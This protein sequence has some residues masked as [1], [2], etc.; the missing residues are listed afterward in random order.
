MGVAAEDAAPVIRELLT[1]GHSANLNDRI[2]EV[3]RDS[4]PRS[5]SDSTGIGKVS[6][7]QFEPKDRRRVQ[8]SP[9][10]KLKRNV[11]NVKSIRRVVKAS[12]RQVAEGNFLISENNFYVTKFV[13]LKNLSL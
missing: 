10:K 1:R 3:R 5:Q 2:T 7:G 6:A 9:R 11:A 8:T 13:L 12:S 4:V